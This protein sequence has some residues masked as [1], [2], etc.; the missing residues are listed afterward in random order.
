MMKRIIRTI[1]QAS[2]MECGV[3]VHTEDGVVTQVEG[4]PQHPSSR[5]FIC[6]KGQAQPELLYHPDRLK[7]PLRRSGG[8]GEGKWERISW[9]EALG[10]IA[11]RLTRIKEEHGPESIASIHGTGPRASTMASRLLTFAL[12]SPNEIS[13]DLHICFAPSL[14]A[15][16]CTVGNSILMEKGPDYLSANCILV[17][18][19]NPL[20]SHPPRGRDILEAQRKHNT[21]LIVVD[22]RRIPLA[23]R[24]DLWLQIRPGTDVALALGMI[25]VIIE[26]Q[27]YD[28][29][30]VDKW[31]YGFDKLT[32]H[33]REY[34][35][36]KIAEITWLP[37][38]KIRQAARMYATAKAA[39]LH[40]RV[41]VEHNINSTQT[42]RALAILAAITGNV[43]VEGGNLFTMSK[44]GYI[45]THLL[46]ADKQFRPDAVI[47]EKRIGSKEFPL[48]SG[49]DSIYQ[50]VHPSLAVETMETDKP[51]PIKALY[52]AG[53]NPLNMQNCKRVWEALKNLELHV[54]ADFFMQPVAE[55]A[56]YVLPAAVW[57]ERDECCDMHYMN[58]IAAR[59]KV[60]EPLYECWDDMK[61]AI[62]LV[63]R[64]P[65][66]DRSFIP[67]ND[68]NEYNEWRVKG[69]GMTFDEL[70]EKGYIVVPVEYKKYEK[71][72]FNTPTGKVELYS[73]VFEKHGYDPL[74]T[75]REP[76]VSPVSTPELIQ[77]YP[78]I[79]FTGGRD[80]AYFHSEGRQISQLRKLVPDPEIEIHPDTARA[81]EI[82]DGDWVWVETPMI[83]S[84][85]VKFKVKLTNNVHPRMV[86]AAHGWWFPEK[87]PP[88]H[89]CFDS[90]INVILSDTGPMEEI[91]G[92]LVTRGT[93]CKV[94]K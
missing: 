81:L 87:P 27:L 23:A 78:L 51:Y 10:E 28:K 49:A 75:F 93:L 7:Y 18:G 3:L 63:K 40:H 60:V 61:I 45:Y 16:R 4:D 79:L 42:D 58:C 38:D 76:P 65:W 82:G 5:G 67:W 20:A 80:I 83:R 19:G 35:P 14:V 74:P 68:V 54:V 77:E 12:G 22:P 46:R 41:A 92:S 26:E 84:E 56:D 34:P 17:F 89:G 37:A 69:M 47:E 88:E 44:E 30:F 32:E 57:L 85:R 62:E 15:E 64:I 48:I 50:F 39:A 43:D 6:V 36:E 53:G 13:T 29:E 91:C 31:C 72:G 71:Q 21:K 24:S 52:C 59:Q 1:C 73:T 66:A 33:V 94:Y 9:G 55:L 70:K 86:Q 90:N 8:R 11:E 2:H 25:N